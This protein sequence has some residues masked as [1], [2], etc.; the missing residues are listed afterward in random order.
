M[1]SRIDKSV[2]SCLDIVI[3]SANLLPYFSR[4]VIDRKQEF[5]PKKVVRTGGKERLI[6]SDHLPILVVLKNMPKAKKGLKKKSHW[7]LMKPGGWEVYKAAMDE[8]SGK[9]DDIVED[10]TVNVEE[11]MKKLTV[12]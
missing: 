12:L 3:I 1:T 4:M 11:V 8:A 9:I 5:C 7:N 6:R 2:K 10:E